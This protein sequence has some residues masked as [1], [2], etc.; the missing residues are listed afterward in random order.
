MAH[1]I[2]R[3][4]AIGQ[5]LVEGGKASDGLVATEGGQQVGKLVLRNVKL[6]DGLTEGNKDRMSR[7]ARVAPLQFRLPL[8]Q[9]RQRLLWDNAD[10][11]YGLGA[12]IAVAA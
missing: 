3:V 7:L 4:V 10:E 1:G 12:R 2:C 11:L 5:H 9:E 6:A 8:V